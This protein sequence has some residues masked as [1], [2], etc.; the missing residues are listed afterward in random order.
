[1][2]SMTLQ[3]ALYVLGGCFLG[4]V[5]GWLFQAA[6]GKRRI[7]ELESATRTEIDNVTGQRDELADKYSN[8]SSTIKSLKARYAKRRTELEFVLEKSRSL[9][10]NILT[11]RTERE[12]TKIKISTFQNALLKMKQQTTA[13]QNEFDKTRAFYKR[14]LVKS[15]DKRKLLDTELE[16]ARAEQESFAKLVESSTLEHGSTQNMVVAAQLRLGQLG[17]LERNITKLEAENAQLSRDLKQVRQESGARERDLAELEELRLHNKQLVRCVEALEGSRKA[18][19][20][21]AE[22]YRDQADQSEKQSETLRLKLDDLEK[23]F[24]NI[25]E[26]QHQALQDARKATVVP[27]LRKQR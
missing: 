23:N 6:I 13:L 22:R 21:D 17:V 19:E 9:A 11:L 16:D 26:Q 8:S 24:A 20:S 14:E 7:F 2:G 5:I 27:I 3:I 25:E 1:M 18:H 4:G 15:F 10:K 12:N